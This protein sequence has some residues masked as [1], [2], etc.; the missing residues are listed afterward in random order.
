MT[1]PFAV[2]CDFDGTVTTEDSTDF[3]LENL[4]DARWKYFEAMW[5]QG[6]ITSKECMAEQIPLIQG[7][8]Q[9]IETLLPRISLEPTFLPFAHWCRSR[10]IP[11]YIVSEGL[12]RVIYHLL[13][14]H[15]VPVTEIWAN[16]LHEDDQNNLYLTFPNPATEITCQAG[17]CKCRILSQAEDTPLKVVIGD[18]L[19]DLCWAS[20]ADLLFAKSKL[21]DYCRKQYIS[22]HA[23]PDF[24]E[25]QEILSPL[26][27]AN[28]GLS[29]I[30]H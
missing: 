14:R 9:A 11:L 13:Q 26:L 7:G 5:E 30:K 23:F 2:Y 12:D 24:T 16:R 29:L 17:L 1:H 28:S 4:A 25:I 22:C 20:N 3:I 10:G 19:S 18:G 6:E 8:W 21:L 27:K 15:N